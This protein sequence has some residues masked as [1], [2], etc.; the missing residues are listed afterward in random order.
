MPPKDDL[1]ASRKRVDAVENL[2]P[3]V[4]RQQADKRVQCEH[5][6]LVALVENGDRACIG[7]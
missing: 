1:V 2:I 7:R 4:F 5:G 6:P 3:A